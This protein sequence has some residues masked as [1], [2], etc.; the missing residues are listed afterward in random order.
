MTAANPS[1][2]LL[3]G[4][5]RSGTLSRHQDRSAV[6]AY[7]MPSRHRVDVRDEYT[8]HCSGQ[9]PPVEVRP[10][11]DG[12]HAWSAK[13]AITSQELLGRARLLLGTV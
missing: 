10:G 13:P 5:P 7:E 8:L 3:I 11:G 6:L 12:P 9:I 2:V 4:F 1:N